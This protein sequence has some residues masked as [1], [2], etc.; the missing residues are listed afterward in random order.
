MHRRSHT[1]SVFLKTKKNLFSGSNQ[2]QQWSMNDLIQINPPPFIKT[3][4]NISPQQSNNTARVLKSPP[5]TYNKR[6]LHQSSL[7]L[8]ATKRVKPTFDQQQSAP[9]L[10]QQLMAP[11]Q[12]QRVR[13]KEDTPIKM[14]P[15]TKW[16]ID[17][18]SQMQLIEQQQQT[19][20]S[21]LKNLL[22]SGCDVSAGY[23]CIVPMRSKKPF[24]A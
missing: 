5:R 11:T 18:N 17:K 4:S 12:Q 22:V 14:E 24:K 8:N 13:L 16:T 1:N 19:S 2:D 20:N 6:P 3:I 10:L 21:V 7:E 9:Q 23:I 15:T